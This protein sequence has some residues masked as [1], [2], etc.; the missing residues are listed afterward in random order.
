MSDEIRGLWIKVE[1]AGLNNHNHC[2]GYRADDE[3]PRNRQIF[4]THDCKS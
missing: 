1:N 2:G 4:D 3:K